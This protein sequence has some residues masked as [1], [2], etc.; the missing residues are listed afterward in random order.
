LPAGAENYL[1]EPFLALAER[2]STPTQ[3]IAAS[4]ALNIAGSHIT[5]LNTV[6]R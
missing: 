3:V 4:N 1:V 5:R 6:W 2:L